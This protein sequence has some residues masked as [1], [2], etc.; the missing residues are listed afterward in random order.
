[1]DVYVYYDCDLVWIKGKKN[2]LLFYVYY[3]LVWIEG[4]R[5]GEQAVI[6]IIA[7]YIYIYG[8]EVQSS[9]GQDD[10]IITI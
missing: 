7:I 6:I 2:K 10:I 9:T 3:D 5:Q 1:M 8:M 4:W